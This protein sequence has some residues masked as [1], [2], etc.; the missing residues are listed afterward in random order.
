M[1]MIFLGRK[2]YSAELLKWTINQG[3]EIRAVVTDSHFP[4][5]PTAKKLKN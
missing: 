2:K 5:S 4:N 3:I 1:K